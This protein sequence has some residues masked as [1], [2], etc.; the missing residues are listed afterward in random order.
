MKFSLVSQNSDLSSKLDSTCQNESKVFKI[1]PQ[2][3]I[4]Q[5]YIQKGIIG[6]TLENVFFNYSSF[7]KSKTAIGFVVSKQVWEWS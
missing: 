5:N 7:G 2:K 3:H 4:N 1:E 6:V